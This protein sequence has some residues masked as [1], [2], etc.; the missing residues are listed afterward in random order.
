MVMPHAVQ[1]VQKGIHV[2]GNGPI[3]RLFEV[4]AKKGCSDE[5]L[6]KFATTSA[7]VVRHEPGNEGYFFGRGVAVDEDVVVF[8]SLWKDMNS[9]RQRFGED[10]QSSFLPA[11]YEDLIDEC[12]VR[13]IDLSSGWHVQLAD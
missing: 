3:M 5:L 12:S 1:S 2:Q 8:A 10:W 9:V 11:G 6:R 4:R 7:D 13:H